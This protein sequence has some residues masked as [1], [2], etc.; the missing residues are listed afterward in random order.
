MYIL[1]IACHVNSTYTLNIISQTR[2]YTLKATTLVCTSA[3]HNNINKRLPKET[4][5]QPC[6]GTYIWADFH[7]QGF[8]LSGYPYNC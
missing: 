7:Y 8:T 6:P 5:L 1:L 4:K 3:V 2:A